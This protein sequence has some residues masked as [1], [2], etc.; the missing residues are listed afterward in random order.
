M[1]EGHHGRYQQVTLKV[2]PVVDPRDYHGIT[3]ESIPAAIEE[4]SD[5]CD[6]FASVFGESAPE[7]AEA[8]D[9]YGKALLA[10]SRIESMVLDNAFEGVE[11]EKDSTEGEH[12]KGTA[13]MTKDES[14]EIEDAVTYAF[15]DNYEEHDR[16][17]RVLDFS[18]TRV[19]IDQAAA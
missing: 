14:L 3:L 19:L 1:T 15:E 7:C 18:Q 17:A 10:M 6:I 5:A 11:I 4:L 13:A 2:A 8:F 12:V 16:V 9:F